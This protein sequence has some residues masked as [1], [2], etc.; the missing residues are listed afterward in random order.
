MFQAHLNWMGVHQRFVDTR[1][2]LLQSTNYYVM[3]HV[4]INFWEIFNACV[5]WTEM[6]LNLSK[7]LLI[8]QI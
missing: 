1:S 5:F 6:F 3:K 4:A 7:R 8:Y 2:F